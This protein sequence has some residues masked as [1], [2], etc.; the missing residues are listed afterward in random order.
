MSICSFEHVRELL[1]VYSVGRELFH[2]KEFGGSG[3]SIAV[4]FQEVD[5]GGMVVGGP[6]CLVV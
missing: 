6:G 5:A 2:F 4:E 1:Y 3:V